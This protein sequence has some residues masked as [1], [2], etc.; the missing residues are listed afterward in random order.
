MRIHSVGARK[1]ADTRNADYFYNYFTLGIDILFNGDTHR[2]KKFLLHTNFPGHYNFNIYYRC[3]FTIRPP[4]RKKSGCDD[5][6]IGSC[7]LWDDVTERLNFDAGR[8]VVLNRT[9]STNNTNPFGS[10]MC[11]GMRNMIFEVMA[12]HHIGSVTLYCPAS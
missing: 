12:N 11:Y 8:P 4:F 7:S 9:S 5:V 10:T 2:V 1:L 6:T 3:D